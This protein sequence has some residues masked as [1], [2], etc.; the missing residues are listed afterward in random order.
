MKHRHNSDALLP[1]HHKAPRKG[2]TDEIV[3]VDGE[4]ITDVANTA[5]RYTFLAASTGASVRGD[6]LSTSLCLDML[7]SLPQRA[8]IVGYSIGYDIN[9]WLKDIPVGDWPCEALPR[10]SGLRGLWRTGNCRWRGYSITWHPGKMFSV[11]VKRRRLAYTKCDGTIGHRV[12]YDRHT[13]VWDVFGFFQSSFVNALHLWDVGT[14]QQRERIERMK[15]KRSFFDD[16]ESTDIEAYCFDECS[17]LVDMVRKLLTY[18]ERIGLK[19]TRYDG[20]GAI[21]AA[22]MRKHHVKNYIADPPGECMDS[23]MRAYIG[24]R[25][26]TAIIGTIKH[27]HAYDVNSAYPTQTLDLP[28]LAHGT[29]STW[30]PGDTVSDTSVIHV[31]WNLCSELPTWGPFPFRNPD[32]SIVYPMA[33]EGYY[34]GREVRAATLMYPIQLLD[35]YTFKA[36]CG[37]RPFAFVADYY[38]QRQTL[39]QAG[40]FGQIILKLGMNSLYGKCAQSIGGKLLARL[41]DGTEVHAKPTYQSFMWAGMITSGTRAAILDALRQGDVVSIATDG[42]IA[43]ERIPSLTVGSELG[44]WE[45]REIHNCTIVQNGVYRYQSD[46]TVDPIVRAR[47]FSGREFNFDGLMAAFTKKRERAE[48]VTSVTRFIGL[49]SSLMRAPVLTDWR[50]WKTQNRTIK[51]RPENRTL[52]R[53]WGLP[54]DRHVVTTRAWHGVFGIS[55][56]YTP[57]TVFAVVAHPDRDAALLAAD[58]A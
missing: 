52:T 30:K 37:H 45:Y 2:R 43:R 36:G 42:V 25:F 51:L 56:P 27:A 1:R 6:S 32:G 58:L 9:M 8:L 10:G 16:A 49:G 48:C 26:E 5:Q 55:H 40:D 33:G 44:T 23:V 39:K 24:G 53:Q 31:R 4:G 38:K 3:A 15:A 29:W 20:A 46:V 50:V 57:K 28:C 34:W 18:S 14:E 19:L 13:T 41:K 12:S 11:G 54:D 47:G 7:L 17:L 35:G 21:A 22:M